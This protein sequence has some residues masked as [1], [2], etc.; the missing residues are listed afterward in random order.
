MVWGVAH[1]GTLCSRGRQRGIALMH[2][3]RE[4][5]CT[6]GPMWR[7]CG[8]CLGTWCSGIGSVHVALWLNW[9]SLRCMWPPESWKLDLPALDITI[10]PKE[11]GK[12]HTNT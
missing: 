3:S 10:E 9:C 12:H 5:N 2:C 8:V 11:D 4:G 6:H 1:K 7:W